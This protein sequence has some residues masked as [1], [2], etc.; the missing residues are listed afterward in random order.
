MHFS[1]PPT[2]Q[3]HFRLRTAAMADKKNLLLLLENP[4]EPVFTQKGKNNAVFDLPNRFLDEQYQPIGAEIQSRFG[5]DAGER[6][7]VRDI[8]L[9]NLDKVGIKQLGKQEN[10]T[11]FLPKHRRLAAALTDLF[12]SECNSRQVIDALDIDFTSTPQRRVTSTPS[13]AW[14]FTHAT[15]STR[16]SSTTPSRSRSSTD[17][18]P[19]TSTCRSSSRASPGSSWTRGPF[20]EPGRRPLSFLKDRVDRSSSRGSSLRPISSRSTGELLMMKEIF[21]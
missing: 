17:P 18:T 19:R 1:P 9:P 3:F 4:S 11:L 2:H 6:I 20:L 14:P 10:F 21:P 5:D 7:P 12:M 13:R 16:N 8:Q 15:V